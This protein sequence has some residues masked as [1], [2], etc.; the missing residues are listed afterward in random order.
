MVDP[1]RTVIEVPAMPPLLYWVVNRSLRNSVRSVYSQRLIQDVV[2]IGIQLELDGLRSTSTRADEES[3]GTL[4]ILSGVSNPLRR[5]ALKFA[6]TGS[7]NVRAHRFNVYCIS[8]LIAGNKVKAKFFGLLELIQVDHVNHTRV[9][10]NSTAAGK[11][12]LQ[13][14]LQ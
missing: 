10:W 12:V 8:C 3:R 6:C 13:K 1:D 5:S 9:R 4:A 14:R 2:F 7:S 11:E